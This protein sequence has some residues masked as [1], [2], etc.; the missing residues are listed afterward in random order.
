MFRDEGSAATVAG[1]SGH[2]FV[3]L[4]LHPGAAVLAQAVPRF[5][6]ANKARSADRASKGEKV[7]P[8]KKSRPMK[9]E[10]QG[11]KVILPHALYMA[12]N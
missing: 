6:G 11:T 8:Q 10:R 9:T 7:F 5:D 4:K 1:V 2:A 3:K 12:R